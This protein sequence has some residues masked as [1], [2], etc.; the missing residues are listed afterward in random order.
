MSLRR[1]FLRNN[2]NQMALEVRQKRGRKRPC[3][4]SQRDL[5]IQ[6]SRDHLW[7]LGDRDYIKQNPI[8]LG[9]QVTNMCAISKAQSSLSSS[10][11]LMDVDPVGH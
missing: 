11:T 3:Y 10:V 4:P 1:M 8:C 6:I 2:P 7:V 5:L 9:T